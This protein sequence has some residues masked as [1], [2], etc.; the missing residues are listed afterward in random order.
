MHVSIG[1]VVSDL[2]LRQLARDLEAMPF[3]DG[4]ATAGWSART[5]KHNAQAAP[6]PLVDA[7]I[8]RIGAYISGN[9]V[10]RLAAQ[11]KRIMGPILSR[12]R[13]GD[14]YGAHVDDAILDGGRTDLAFTLFL[15]DPSAYDGGEL[16]IDGPGG[17]EMHKLAAGCLILYPATTLHRV[18]PVTRGTR[19]AAIGWVR[20][21]IRS[22]ERR[23]LLFD[24]ETA[25][26]RLFAAHGKTQDFDLLSKCSANLMRLW[27][28][29]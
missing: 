6:D 10:F 23:E 9:D 3:A 13:S 29:D 14:H 8:E 18:A 5:V 26:R 7:W 28:D 12:Y 16:I 1:T 21:L 4:R 24:L 22:A 19:Y 17:E 27:C 25:R 11:P 2:D 20:S 15:A